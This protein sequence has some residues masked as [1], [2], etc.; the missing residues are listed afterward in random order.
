M[1]GILGK[2]FFRD[3]PGVTAKAMVVEA[4]ITMTLMQRPTVFKFMMILLFQDL[5]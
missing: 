5:L 3:S 2:F 1:G 4:R